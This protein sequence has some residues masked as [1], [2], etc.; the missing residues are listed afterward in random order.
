MR[1]VALKNPPPS[2]QEFR[3]SSGKDWLILPNR[4]QGRLDVYRWDP[5]RQSTSS[6]LPQSSPGEQ[7]NELPMAPELEVVEIPLE[8]LPHQVLPLPSTEGHFDDSILVLAGPPWKLILLEQQDG[9]WKESYTWDLLPGQPAGHPGILLHQPDGGPRQVLIGFEEGIQIIRPEQRDL[10]V[11]HQPADKFSRR[12]WWLTDLRGTG[13][14][15]LVEWS[16][17][18]QQGIRI[19]KWDAD[20]ASFLPPQTISEKNWQQ[21]DIL[22]TPEG[23]DQVLLMSGNPAGIL[24]RYQLQQDT[25]DDYAV[26][27]PL[28]WNRGVESWTGISIDDKP[29]WVGLATTPARLELLSIQPDGGWQYRAN[30]PVLPRTRAVV[31]HPSLSGTLLLQVEGAGGLYSSQW[32]NQRFSFPTPLSSEAE[33]KDSLV[34]GLEALGDQ[35]WSTR[36][37]GDDIELRI[38]SKGQAEPE[39]RLFRNVG[40]QIEKA[41]WA[42]GDALIFQES[43]SRNLKIARLLPDGTTVVR[44]PASLRQ[45]RIEDFST[46]QINGENMTGRMVDGVW[47]WLDRDW[48]PKDQVM[49]P[50]GLSLTAFLPL[51]VTQALAIDSSAGSLHRLQADETGVFRSTKRLEIPPSQG[52]YQDPLLG[53]FLLRSDKIERLTHGSP[54]KLELIESVDGRITRSSGTKENTIHR[55]Q[56]ADISDS[57]SNE[58]LLFNDQTATLSSMKLQDG[59]FQPLVS[60]Q[61]FENSSYPYG[62]NSRDVREEPR[63]LITLDFDGDGVQDMAMV[64]HDRLILYLGRDNNLKN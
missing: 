46:F 13:S 4:H 25:E 23:R 60:W 22:H 44:E 24:R 53:L 30:F 28:A 33:S 37:Q 49:L 20:S 62:N 29:H 10:P 5:E 35:V 64:C 58:L 40:K 48:Q 16:R 36:R 63:L 21:M 9:D 42:G 50:D 2:I 41:R 17:N 3:D 27:Y 32:S 39:V 11:W 52:L 8:H 54:W 26:A 45:T 43:F 38:W 19:H 31:N 51:S 1:V 57:D 55:F 12:K 59:K 6:S 7:P 56:T 15:D 34:L 14:P 61:V 18:P 47:Q